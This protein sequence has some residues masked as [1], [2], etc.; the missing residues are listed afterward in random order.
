MP[1]GGVLRIAT[2]ILTAPPPELGWQSNQSIAVLS[3]A[4]TGIGMD[5]ETQSR[6]FELF[7]TTK[8]EGAGYGLGLAN[9]REIVTLHGGQIS[10]QSAA[11][12]GTCF[13]IHMPL[14]DADQARLSATGEEPAP[15][16]TVPPQSSVSVLL[17]DDDP[18]VR[19]SVARRLRLAGL[20]VTEASDG[21]E[22]LNQ[23]GKQP[24]TLVVLDFDMPGLDGPDTQARLMTTDPNVRIVFATGYADPERATAVRVRGALALLEKPYSLDTLIRLARDASS[25][26]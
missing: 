6:L 11:G 12:E 23:Y 25:A 10:L 4:D 13:T 17:V 8:R 5:L 9:V 26:E 20:Q 19:R 7:Y 16:P 14:L 15:A 22:A 21:I 24:H 3:V 2:S 18:V 1:D